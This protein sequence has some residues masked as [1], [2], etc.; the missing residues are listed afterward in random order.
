[1]TTTLPF[2]ELD[3]A[4]FH[5]ENTHV[6]WNIQLEVETTTEIDRGKLREAAMAACNTHPMARVRKVSHHDWDSNYAWELPNSIDRDPVTVVE[7]ESLPTVRGTFY[8]D[9]IDLAESPPFRLCVLRGAGRSGGDRLLANV[10][11]V[12]AD[13]IGATRLLRSICAVYRDEELAEDPVDLP[14]SRTVLD[15]LRPSSLGDRVGRLGAAASKLPEALDPPAR[16]ARVGA[17]DRGGWGFVHRRLEESLTERLVSDRA[18]NVSVNDLLLAALHLSI[19]RWNAEHGR[20]SGRI[21]ITMPVNLRPREWFYDVVGMYAL[22]VSVSTRPSDRDSPA[23]A[24]AAVA[25]ETSKLKQPD[26][27]AALHEALQMIPPGVPVG[28]KQQMPNLLDGAGRNLLDTAVLSNLGRIPDPTPTLADDDP[29]NLWFSPPCWG[30]IGVG[31][32]VAT[33][34]GRIHLVFRHGFDRFD[35]DAAESFAELYLDRLSAVA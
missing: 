25:E 4:V 29:E 20:S 12:A 35:A 26:R 3:E 34:G 32:G 6:P 28:F 2:T 1:M 31:I 16:I 13:G 19:D 18:E 17:S 33:V 27:S 21:A 10:S 15:D 22:F 5:L 9:E 11:H 23:E 7:G 30:P 8:A 24:V 14:T